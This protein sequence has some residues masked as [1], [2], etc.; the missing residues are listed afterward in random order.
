MHS[1]VALSQLEA[2]DRAAWRTRFR[3]P[4]ELKRAADELAACGGPSSLEAGFAS[5]HYAWHSLA[6]F[7]QLTAAQYHARATEIFEH[8][9]FGRGLDRLRPVKALILLRAGKS[10]AALEA[11]EAQQRAPDDDPLAEARYVALNVRALCFGDLG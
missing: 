11:T 8:H 3:D 9:H 6:L 7:D 10:Q 4:S 5:L 1:S 2:L